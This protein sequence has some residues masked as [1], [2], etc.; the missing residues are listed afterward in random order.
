MEV[1]RQWRI[2]GLMRQGYEAL[3]HL[4]DEDAAY[5]NKRVEELRAGVDGKSGLVVGMHVRHGDRHPREFQYQK[6]YIPLDRYVSAAR[7]FLPQATPSNSS[8]D[9]V[10]KVATGQLIVASDDPDVY[11]DAEMQTATRAQDR[12]ML[13]SKSTLDAL[14]GNKGGNK[15]I[16]KN[17][18]WEGGFYKD[19]FW[20]LGQP[21]SGATKKRSPRPSKSALPEVIAQQ[22]KGIPEQALKLRELVGRAYLLDL[23]VLGRSDRVVCG[24]S[25]VGCRLLA[26]MMGWEKGIVDGG[27]R[28]VDGLWD[29]KGI[30]W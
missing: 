22:G 30:V 25:A 2:F 7:E 3:F 9:S 20:G 18:G 11:A 23:A 8:N 10:P 1:M 12:I 29:W 27:W 6:S 16:D 24:V 15:F 19:I 17:I 13:A 5:M 28:N 4:S 26:V 21:P 14:S